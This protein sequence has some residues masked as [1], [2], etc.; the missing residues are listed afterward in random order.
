[1]RPAARTA[2][3][4]SATDGRAAARSRTQRLSAAAKTSG[5]PLI[6]FNQFMTSFDSIKDCVAVDVR[7]SPL[8]CAASLTRRR[9]RRRNRLCNL[10]SVKLLLSLRRPQS[11]GLAV[12][13]SAAVCDVISGGCR[14]R[15]SS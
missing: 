2:A 12:A 7:A 15:M 6:N 5:I 9:R 10:T 13:D 1:V 3:D 11:R 14:G 4:P 8:S